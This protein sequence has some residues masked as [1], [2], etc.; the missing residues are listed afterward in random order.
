MH[1]SLPFGQR[2]GLGSWQRCDAGVVAATAFLV[3]R[4][5]DIRG[6]AMPL[7]RSPW[8]AI[9]H[10][11]S[12]SSAIEHHGRPASAAIEYHGRLSLPWSPAIAGP[13]KPLPS[14]STLAT[15]NGRGQFSP[16]PGPHAS[17][18]SVTGKTVAAVAIHRRNNAVPKSARPSSQATAL[19][20]GRPFGHSE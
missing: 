12:R 17:R 6:A 16:F 14:C 5:T 3:G 19:A 4:P 18:S 11:G 9:E 7:P 1:P 8:T 2:T 13:H 15:A 20:A 10:H